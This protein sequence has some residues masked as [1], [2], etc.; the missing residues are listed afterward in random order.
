[1]IGAL[2]HEEA[3]ALYGETGRTTF[4]DHMLRSAYQALVESGFGGAHGL[5]RAG[6]SLAAQPRSGPDGFGGDRPGRRASA[7]CARCRGRGPRTAWPTSF[8]GS[9]ADTTGAGRVLL[10]TGEAENLRSGPS[11]ITATSRPSTGRGP[12]CPMT[13]RSSAASWTRLPSHRHRLRPSATR[14]AQ[15]LSAVRRLVVPITVQDKTIGVVYA[16]QARARQAASRTDHEEARRLPVRPG[17]R[18]PV[19]LPAGGTTTGRRRIPAVTDG[20]A[21]AVRAQRTAA[22]PRHRRPSPRP[23]RLSRRTAR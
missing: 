3:A 16:E 2:A 20:R 23:Q 22:H 4:R 5:A 1:M 9:V 10:L 14:L 12:R 17:R 18:A 6:A 11:T 19:E 13:P 7:V 21:I 8:C 15:A